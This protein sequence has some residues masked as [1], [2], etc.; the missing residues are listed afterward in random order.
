[1]VKHL[2]LA[3]YNQSYLVDKIKLMSSEDINQM[4]SKDKMVLAN[5]L[6]H[7]NHKN[8]MNEILIANM[9]QRKKSLITV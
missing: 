4:E 9:L 3:Q 2:P 1:M 7:N 8:Q 6:L 5:H